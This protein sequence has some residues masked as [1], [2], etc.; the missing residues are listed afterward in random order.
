MLSESN[1]LALET[2]GRKTNAMLPV[3]KRQS[4]LSEYSLTGHDEMRIEEDRKKWRRQSCPP[5]LGLHKAREGFEHPVLT[6]PG[7]F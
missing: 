6:L 4:P 3:N 1:L 7:A 5:E 2:R